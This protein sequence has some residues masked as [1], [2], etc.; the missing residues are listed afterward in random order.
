MGARS[1]LDIDEACQQSSVAAARAAIDR[2]LGDSD[3]EHVRP[4]LRTLS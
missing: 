4:D 1:V 2:L 3:A